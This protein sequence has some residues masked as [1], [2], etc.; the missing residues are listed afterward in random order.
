M[1]SEG[2]SKIELYLNKRG[3]S[4]V[5]EKTFPDCKRIQPLRYDFYLPDYNILIEYDGPQ[6]FQPYP[7]SYRRCRNFSVWAM[8]KAEENFIIQRENDEIKNRYALNNGIQL[9]RINSINKI[10]RVLNKR[11]KYEI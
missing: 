6:H 10:E 7:Q 4:F 2:E 3:I 8:K 11:L 9:I 5:R 1:K